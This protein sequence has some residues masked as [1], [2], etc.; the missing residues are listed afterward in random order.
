MWAGPPKDL[1]P[2]KNG[3]QLNTTTNC[4]P[5]M[6]I[7]IFGQPETGIDGS[8]GHP[9]SPNDHPTMGAGGEINV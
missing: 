5:T 3:W 2:A 1:A 9:T 6:P 8:H 7:P 4:K